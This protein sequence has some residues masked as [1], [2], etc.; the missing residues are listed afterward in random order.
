MKDNKNLRQ[1]SALKDNHNLIRTIYSHKLREVT[2]S[3]IFFTP[4][5]G[6]ICTKTKKLRWTTIPSL[7]PSSKKL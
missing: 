6:K 3:C 4:D 7:I 1:V 5:R 2:T